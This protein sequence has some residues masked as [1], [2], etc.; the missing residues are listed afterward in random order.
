M[1]ER[2]KQ[3]LVGAAVLVSLAVI[4]VPMLLDGAREPEPRFVVDD[5]PDRPTQED[6]S[7]IIPLEDLDAP[8]GSPASDA[9]RSAPEA[10][11]EPGVSA[12]A[13]E[14]ERDAPSG[15]PQR[16]G[17]PT[18]TAAVSAWV[19]QLGSFARSQNAVA[20]RDQLRAKGYTAF[21]ESADSDQGRVTRVYVGP[22][23]RRAQ[24]EQALKKLQG[25]VDLKGIVVR[26]PG[27]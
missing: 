25:E 15:G 18:D 27:G 16:P 21:L 2:L 7:P 24:A 22:E 14:A 11:S 8:S 9:D 23:L 19:V 20:L 5:I 1:D 12:A 6:A 26:Y 4:F 17:A 3:R 10:T 13:V